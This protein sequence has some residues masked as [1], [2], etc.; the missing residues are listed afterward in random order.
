MEEIKVISKAEAVKMH[1]TPA[2]I[3][4]FEKYGKLKSKNIEDSLIKT[5]EQN[6]E[7]VERVKIGRAFHYQVGKKLSK[8][9]DRVDGRTTNGDWSIPYTK[10]MDIIVA[11]AIEEGNISTNA[12]TMRKWLLD[13][14]LIDIKMF[15]LIGLSGDRDPK[16]KLRVV[17]GLVG[18]EVIK[19]NE[20]KI[21]DDLIK[22]SLE[23]QGQ[24][25]S[26]LLRMKK[27]GL[28]D[29]YEVYKA[30]LFVFDDVEVIN[31]HEST[32]NEINRVKIEIRQKYGLTPY[33]FNNLTNMPAVK[34][35]RAEFKDFLENHL[36]DEKGNQLSVDFYWKAWTVSLKAGTKRVAKYL[37]KY[38][39]DMI[40][41]FNSDKVE[42]LRENKEQF[43]QL[44]K[45][46]VTEL[47]EKEVEKFHKDKEKDLVEKL[48]GKHKPAFL[49]YEYDSGYY[50]LLISK[51][52]VNKMVE[53]QEYF[54]FSL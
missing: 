45:Q 1:G 3:A 14:G 16:A 34:E 38:S 51:K 2:Q 40:E 41:A 4:H 26:S 12:Q 27:A 21:V 5:L 35:A 43:F 8:A 7:S 13:F 28:I 44:R 11:T 54:S 10:N 22:F 39:P 31:L 42:F 9:K 49:D 19:F 52:Y 23:L 29:F 15:K 17:N 18:E 50:D 20:K 6:Y 48:G 30:K 53:L 46:R 24:L 33:E 47:A 25:E 37:K 32:K 36:V